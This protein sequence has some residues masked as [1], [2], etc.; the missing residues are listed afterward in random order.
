M[1]QRVFRFLLG[2]D[3]APLSVHLPHDPLTPTAD[4]VRYFGCAIHFAQ[5]TAGFTMRT[6][7]LRHRL[8]PDDLAHRAIVDYLG[9]ITPKNA[10]FVQSIRT[11]IR[12]LLPTGA[13]TLDVVADQFNLHPKTLQRRLADE[14]TT[15][16]GLVDEVREEAAER[17]LRTTHITMSHLARELGY[18]EQSVLSRACKRW[19]GAGP[20]AYRSQTRSQAGQ[21][22]VAR[23]TFTGRR[24]GRRARRL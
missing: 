10:D 3:F 18:A 6:S 23:P 14:D 13:A 7:D 9:R 22:D 19:F 16:A 4:Y 24:G 11:V 8:H 17:Y 15:F 2:S 12:Q 21:P 5:R 1:S 20:A